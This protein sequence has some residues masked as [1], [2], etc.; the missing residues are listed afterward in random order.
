MH[1]C[2]NIKIWFYKA[3]SNNKSELVESL[4]VSIKKTPKS[5]FMFP[6]LAKFK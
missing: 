2:K 3:L 4:M 1:L 6:L 5:S